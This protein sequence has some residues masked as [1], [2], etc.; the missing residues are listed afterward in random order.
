MVTDN[1][2]TTEDQQKTNTAQECP[3]NLATGVKTPIFDFDWLCVGSDL[4]LSE[5]TQGTLSFGLAKTKVSRSRFFLKFSSNP[6][7][8]VFW[9]G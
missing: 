9:V 6:R 5:P 8:T 7:D 1:D 2:G 3:N 4:D